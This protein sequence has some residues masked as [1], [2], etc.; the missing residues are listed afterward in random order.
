M[1]HVLRYV[2]ITRFCGLSGYT[3]EA[4]KSKRRDGVWLEGCAWIKAP[5]S[6]I[7]IDLEDYEAWVESGR[8]PNRA[9]RTQ[10]VSP[11]PPKSAKS[12]PGLSPKPIA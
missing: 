12:A 11:A 3:K 1:N 7:L 5:D 10:T 6:R 2:T 4:V 9:A 8:L